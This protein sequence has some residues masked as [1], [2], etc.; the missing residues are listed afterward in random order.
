VFYLIRIYGIILWRRSLL[1][2]L[3]RGVGVF[4]SRKVEKVLRAQQ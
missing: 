3:L 1:P 4:G 2:E